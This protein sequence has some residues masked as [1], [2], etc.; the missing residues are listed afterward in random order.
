MVHFPMGQGRASSKPGAWNS[1]QFSHV[2]AGELDPP[3]TRMGY[4]NH[5]WWLNLLYHNS[6]PIYLDFYKCV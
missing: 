5:K 4:W 3:S 1:T 6:S 2:V